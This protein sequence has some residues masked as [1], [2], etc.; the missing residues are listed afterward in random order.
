MRTN[1]S[2]LIIRVVFIVTTPC[3]FH[4]QRKENCWLIS[5]V[6]VHHSDKGIYPKYSQIGMACSTNKISVWDLI[7]SWWLSWIL[8]S[9]MWC[10]V[11][12]QHFG[13][14]L[15]SVCMLAWLTLWLWKWRQS[16]PPRRHWTIRLHNVTSQKTVPLQN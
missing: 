4:L 9:V 2:I 3:I 7:L 16:V 13:A 5:E 12:Y 6:K 15:F 1:N 8:P 14:P 11:I 10:L